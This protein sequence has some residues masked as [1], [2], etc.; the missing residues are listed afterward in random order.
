M[1]TPLSKDIRKYIS[2]P[3]NARSLA[4][5]LRNSKHSDHLS[6]K[7]NGETINLKHLGNINS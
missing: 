2:S 1:K 7:L 5:Q 3:S 4:N 6:V